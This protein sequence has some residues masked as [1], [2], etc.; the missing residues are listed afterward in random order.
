MHWKNC[1]REKPPA[2]LGA[3]GEP[4]CISE[5]VL[6]YFL[7]GECRYDVANYD[8]REGTWHLPNQGYEQPDVEPGYWMEL[9]FQPGEPCPIEKAMVPMSDSLNTPCRGCGKTPLELMDFA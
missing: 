4:P 9:P 5:D 2:K 8:H 6:V 7:V 1:N 3:E